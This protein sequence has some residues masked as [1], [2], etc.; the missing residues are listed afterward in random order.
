MS[1]PTCNQDHQRRHPN[2]AGPQ[3]GRPEQAP[4]SSTDSHSPWSYIVAILAVL[5]W[6][7]LRLLP[8]DITP[9]APET[10]LRQEVRRLPPPRRLPQP[11]RPFPS[12]DPRVAWSLL[13]HLPEAETT[14]R[15]VPA[16][17]S[18]RRLIG[19]LRNRLSSRWLPAAGDWRVAGEGVLTCFS[20]PEEPGRL[21]AAL[22]P[23]PPEPLCWIRVQLRFLTPPGP[24]E[25]AGLTPGLDAS[26]SG[27]A[28]LVG[29][30]GARTL[31]GEWVLLKEY[32]VTQVLAQMRTSAEPFPSRGPG[33]WLTVTLTRAEG[34]TWRARVSPMVLG[35]EVPIPAGARPGVLLKSVGTRAAFF[36]FHLE[37]ESGREAPG[38]EEEALERRLAGAVESLRL[39]DLVTS[40][41]DPN[42]SYGA[43]GEKPRLPVRWVSIDGVARPAVLAP[44]P[45]ELRF[46]LPDVPGRARFETWV[47]IHPRAWSREGSFSRPDLPADEFRVEVVLESD[48]GERRLWRKN[49][50]APRD[51]RW[52]KAAVSLPGVAAG[53]ALVLRARPTESGRK[54]V[55]RGGFLLWGNPV[56]RFSGSGEG[57]RNVILVVVDSLRADALGPLRPRGPQ[58]SAG[59][60][61]AFLERVTGEGFVFE[62][63][64]SQAPWC[65]PALASLHSSLWPEVHGTN[66]LDFRVP[67]SLSPAA[68]TLAEVL[69]RA[70]YHTAWISDQPPPQRV[71]LEQGFEE[72]IVPPPYRTAFEPLFERA[73]RWV[74]DEA[75][76][77][78]FLYVHTYRLARAV[79]E[80]LAEP[81]QDLDLL[82]EKLRRRYRESVAAV[83]EACG[84]F[85][86]TLAEDGLA[87][88]TLF[89]LTSDHGT[90]LCERYPTIIPGGPGF[91]LR[92]E[93]LHVPLIIRPPGGGPAGLGG[94]EPRRVTAPVRLIDLV[95]TVCELSGVEPWPD[96]QGA[97]LAPLMRTGGEPAER[98]VFASACNNPPERAALRCLGYKYI[99]VLRPEEPRGHIFLEPLA[100]EQ[101]YNVRE[102]PGETENLAER[103]PERLA[104]MRRMLQEHL[105]R[106][107]EERR[108]RFPEAPASEPAPKEDERPERAAD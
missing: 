70:G 71:N 93:Q 58:G 33:P 54:T 56:L 9:E 106:T 17:Q 53:D 87:Q 81:P 48:A 99:R 27:P 67:G 16:P 44:A 51:S 62:N 42:F 75:R 39:A 83:T 107:A 13:D 74:R 59:V 91:T 45:S 105:R 19:T 103:E 52:V 22:R 60:G 29:Y 68:V 34:G 28:F 24:E 46:P 65:V 96:W 20:P 2:R 23:P 92:D 25:R 94:A 108:R 89:I 4:P 3:E 100:D 78:F 84:G 41:A 7:A 72:V 5:L 77:P 31:L 97:S 79:S 12:Y 86:E 98:P 55:I 21:A 10:A 8:G 95:P 18:L 66:P 1:R 36:G 15:E 30:A 37:T 57:R 102:D 90:D 101:L 61:G 80:V 32:R 26:G 82:R 38:P 47:G 69:R 35:A 50:K 14:V 40:P 85:F 49:L 104:R 11:P 63:A 43:P 76:E 6:S 88:R 64:F 73:A